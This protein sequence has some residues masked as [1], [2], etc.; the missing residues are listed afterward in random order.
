MRMREANG[1]SISTQSTQTGE[2]RATA[3]ALS[4][5]RRVVMTLGSLAP[6]ALFAHTMRDGTTRA[7][8]PVPRLDTSS[9]LSQ[10]QPAPR[11]LR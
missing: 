7:A 8:L 2:H 9:P 11:S 4:L 5:S 1:T 3:L 10:R 6:R